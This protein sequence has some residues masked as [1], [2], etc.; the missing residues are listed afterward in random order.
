MTRTQLTDSDLFDIEMLL[1]KEERNLE[2]QKLEFEKLNLPNTVTAQESRIE[3][4]N[5]L[6]EKIEQIRKENK[7]NGKR[8]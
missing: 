5:K 3:H 4:N 8:D 1:L 6:L 2:E 7:Q